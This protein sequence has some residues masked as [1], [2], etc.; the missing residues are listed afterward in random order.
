[1]M[2]TPLE[3]VDSYNSTAKF[4]H[5]L[6]AVALVVQWVV[7]LTV[8]YFARPTKIALINF[9]ATFGTII[10]LLVLARIVWRLK[11]GVPSLPKGVPALMRLASHGTQ[12]LFYLLLIFVPLA[13]LGLR[14][15]RGDG[16]NLVMF[17]LPSPLAANKVLA[18][19]FGQ[20]HA[21][22]AYVLLGLAG[23]HILAALYHHFVRADGILQRML[24]S[25]P[26]TR[27]SASPEATPPH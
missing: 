14:L 5:W 2:N 8:D 21:L 9:H 12:I 19:D 6:I 1:M 27:L 26:M 11:S 15:S 17:T 13:G 4:L 25:G 20:V 22:A 24:P 16:I 18:H 23:L 10:L 7:G 3:N